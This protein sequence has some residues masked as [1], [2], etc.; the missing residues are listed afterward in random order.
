V[1]SVGESVELRAE[2]CDV[3]SLAHLYM[4]FFGY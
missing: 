4:P 2:G 3:T 1:S